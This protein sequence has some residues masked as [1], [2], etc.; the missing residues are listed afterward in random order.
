MIELLKR[1]GAVRISSDV[2]RS[3][4]TM[5]TSTIMKT[6]GLKSKLEKSSLNIKFTSA[7]NVFAESTK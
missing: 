2:I 4:D 1:L 7:L 6:N 5:L 3:I